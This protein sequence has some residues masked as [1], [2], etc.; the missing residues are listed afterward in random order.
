MDNWIGRTAHI[1]LL[2][3]EPFIRMFV[4]RYR[5]LLE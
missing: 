4:V 1:K 2:D 5:D 3:C